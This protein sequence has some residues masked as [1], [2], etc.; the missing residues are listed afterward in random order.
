MCR[1]L[2]T[3]VPSYLL[4]ARLPNRRV[5]SSWRAS[6]RRWPP[7]RGLPRT[8]RSIGSAG[9]TGGRAIELLRNTS[10]SSRTSRWSSCLML[11]RQRTLGYSMAPRDLEMPAGSGPRL[12][13]SRALQARPPPVS[14]TGWGRSTGTTVDAGSFGAGLPERNQ[15]LRM[16]GQSHPSPRF[17]ILERHHGV[18]SMSEPTDCA[19]SKN[20]KR[21]FV[22]ISTAASSS[23]MEVFCASSCLRKMAQLWND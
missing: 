20:W 12:S 16:A 8:G 18:A 4:S 15:S 23:A 21:S 9:L 13:A 10:T 19:S 11:M 22:T 3:S 6:S 17:R 14:T 5:Y 7:T 1:H 2:G